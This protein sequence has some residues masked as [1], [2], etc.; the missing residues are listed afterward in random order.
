MTDFGI[1]LR[2]SVTKSEN[3]FNKILRFSMFFFC[4]QFFSDCA[5]ISW[6]YLK[7]RLK[8]LACWCIYSVLFQFIDGL[9]VWNGLAHEL[10]K[11]SDMCL[12]Q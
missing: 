4:K 5:V 10:P 7:I 6:V 3:F 8:Y 2:R 12:D 9:I 1:E 11:L